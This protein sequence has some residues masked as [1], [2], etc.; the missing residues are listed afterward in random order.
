MSAPFEALLAA[1][2]GTGTYTWSLTSGAL[3]PGLTLADGAIAG[4]PTTAGIYRFTATVTDS[5]GRV[6]NYPARIVVADKL[7]IS[8]VLLP[9]RDGRQ[10][11]LPAKLKTLGGVKPATWRIVRGPLP[12]GFRFDRTTGQLFGIPTRPG[13]YRVTFE[14]TDALGVTAKKTLSIVVLATPKPKKLTTGEFRVL[15]SASIL[16]RASPVPLGR[17]SLREAEV[18]RT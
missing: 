16:R 1:T 11:L 15:P 17:G 4:T 9:S 13:R 8:T 7:A 3:P 10:A 5:E 14:A 6:A 18:R 2:G 12:R